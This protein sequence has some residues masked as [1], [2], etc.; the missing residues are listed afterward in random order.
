MNY[1]PVPDS[2]RKSK[3]K[4]E[5]DLSNYATKFDL[6]VATRIDTLKFAK[7]TDGASLKLDVDKLDADKLE[8]TPVGFRKL[9]SKSYLLT[10]LYMMNWLKTLMQFRLLILVI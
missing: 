8:T 2:Y 1:F 4:V 6:K 5:L 10:R 7:K 3:I 9:S